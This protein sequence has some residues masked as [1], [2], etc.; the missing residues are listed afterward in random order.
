MILHLCL[1]G[2]IQVVFSG[3]EIYERHTKMSMLSW[4]L[5]I[6]LNV[7]ISRPLGILVLGSS[8]IAS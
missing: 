5:E 3:H 2:T 8:D 7:T 1:S 6:G 4:N